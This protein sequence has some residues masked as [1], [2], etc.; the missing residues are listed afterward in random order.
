[1]NFSTWYTD[2]ADVWRVVKV[3]DGALT[4]QERQQVL[5][6]IPCRIFRSSSKIPVIK[7]T[8]AEVN[9][10][11]KLACDNSYLIKPGDELLV[12]RGA[13]LG[14]IV[15]EMRAIAG[16]ADNY[17]EPFGGVKPML[18][19]QEIT[20]LQNERIGGGD[21]GSETTSGCPC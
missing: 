1:M 14:Q 15:S 16:E 10:D 2:T 20:L 5:T 19:H 6:A 17:F 9:Q 13:G 18:A 3:K 4:R 11:L 21:D 8:A 12:H 7:Q